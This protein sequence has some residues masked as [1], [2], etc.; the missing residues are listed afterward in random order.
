MYRILSISVVVLAKDYNPSIISKEWLKEK[1]I[2]TET[3]KN[4]IHTPVLSLVETEQISLLIDANR[5]QLSP[6]SPVLSDEG[7]FPPRAEKLVSCL[8]ETPYVAVGFNFHYSV[9]EGSY[10]A[11]KL[12][13]PNEEYLSRIFT[14]GYEIGSTVVFRFNKFTAR[15]AISP[16]G[17]ENQAVTVDFNFHCDVSS[18]PE[19]RKRLSA[20][21]DVRK[22]TID[23]MEELCE[24]A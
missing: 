16:P 8:P 2:I 4:F 20:H 3:V 21:V 19:V 23:I 7:D 13:S 1:G 9:P 22:T 11:D 15:L 5:L 17:L 6:K 14:E 10:H 12:F 18:E 24:N